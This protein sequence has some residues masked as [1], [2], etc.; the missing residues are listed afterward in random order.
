MVASERWQERDF[1]DWYSATSQSEKMTWKFP[2]PCSELHIDNTSRILAYGNGL[3]FIIYAVNGKETLSA[4][5]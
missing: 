1:N 2:P 5:D 4:F 3:F